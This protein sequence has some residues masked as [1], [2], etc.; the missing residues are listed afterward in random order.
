MLREVRQNVASIGDVDSP[1]LPSKRRG[2]AMIEGPS[3]KTVADPAGRR[4]MTRIRHAAIFASGALSPITSVSR[5]YLSAARVRSS[6]RRKTQSP[7]AQSAVIAV[8]EPLLPSN[9]LRRAWTRL[10]ARCNGAVCDG[11]DDSAAT[12]VVGAP[13]VAPYY[14]LQAGLKTRLY[15]YPRT[16]TSHR[17]TSHPRTPLFKSH[18]TRRLPRSWR[19][20]GLNT[21][22]YLP[23][24]LA[25]ETAGVPDLD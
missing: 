9:A 16:G 20:Q 13:T 2:T 15:V 25:G 12:G 3:A 10:C 18:T 17:R 6:G 19:S 7:R 23:A 22:G 4:D 11:I 21:R 14:P 5:R 1:R 8:H 24:N